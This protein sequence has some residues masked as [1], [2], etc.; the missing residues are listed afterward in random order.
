MKKTLIFT[1]LLASVLA[2]GFSQAGNSWAVNNTATWIE[3]V[4][5]I[6][7]GGNNKQYTI[8]VT[9]NISVPASNESTFGTATGITV[10]IEGSGTLSPSANGSLLF[11]GSGQTIVA[12]DV[13]LQGRT[14]NNN[15]ASVVKIDGGTFRMVGNAKVTG[16]TGFA[17]TGVS[18][19]GHY[20][21]PSTFIMDGGTVSGITG[22][23]AL[24]VVINGNCNG[25]FTM[26]GGTISGN[27]DRGVSCRGDGTITMVDGTI[28]G[29]S[30]GGV[31]I[32]QDATFTM[33]GGSITGNSASD[34]S[35]R[36]WDE[37]W[38]GGGGVCNVGGTFNMHGG[39]ISN[40]TARDYG[41]GV[42]NDSSS[43]SSGTFTM[44]GGTISNNSSE[45]GGGV[46]LDSGSFVMQGNASVSGNTANWG[47]EV[48]VESTFTMK[49]NTSVSGNTAAYGGGVYVS[50]SYGT[51]TMESGTISGNTATFSG[52]GVYNSGRTFTKTGG[53]IYGGDAEQNLKNTVI[54]RLGHA[55]YEEK[56]IAWRNST[57]GQTMNSNSYGF[58]LNDGDV[59]VFPSGFRG[60]RRRNNFNNTLTLTENT[61][62]SSTSNNLWVLQSISG[63]AYTFKRSNAA[64][65]M[66][67]TIR[68]QDRN[69]VIS[70][71]SGSGQ[72]NW[73]GTWLR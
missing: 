61:I 17:V 29:N 3:A 64:N 39:T 62:R 9:G 73:N 13:T 25:T 60:T 65:T 1:V 4:G 54:S 66:T 72:D 52:G 27:S 69:L 45:S 63:D 40:N 71:D 53:T 59:V 43:L 7:G 22:D 41:G 5:G 19:G 26:N 28:S 49:D 44:Q 37:F 14:N 67:L 70:G 33:R 20:N 6:R 46:H 48:N 12:K 55:M 35:I 16:N 30:G 34:N 68:L 57:A 2:L 21:P 50:G 15:N 18:I 42:Y 24:G 11:I 8:T 56:N 38:S 31:Y 58:W 32:W 36:K 47:G 23:Y 10:S 51:F